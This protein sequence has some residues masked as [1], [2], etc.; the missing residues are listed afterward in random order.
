MNA[1]ESTVG[2]IGLGLVGSALAERFLAAG[3]SVLG[4]DLDAA[5][6][7]EHRARGGRVAAS[8][9]EVASGAARIV[10]SLPDSPAVENVIE[11]VRTARAA[12]TIIIDTTTGDPAPTAA[13][14]AALAERGIAYVDATISGSSAQ[15][16]SGTVLVLAGGDA[17]AIA[18]C[19]DLF[20]AFA[21]QVFHVGPAGDGSRMKLV[22]NLVLGLNRAVL[23]EGLALARSCGL[24]PATA[25]EILRAGPAYS[26][27]M[28]TK[29]AKMLAGDFTPQ[30]R[31]AQHLKDV[32]LILK[33][34][35]GCHARLP[36]SGLHHELLGQLAAQGYQGAD[37]SAIIRAFWPDAPDQGKETP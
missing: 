19:R 12:G 15:V 23:A 32:G 13:M 10:L 20:A 28:D 9:I 7:D 29:G 2:L 11:S 21:E 18:A 35:D 5:R 25:L 4:F 17:R 37:N 26:R 3:L 1:R 16:R 31:L 36:F 14:G 34:G 6:C 24:D 27:V 33:M 30:A 22:V 8:A